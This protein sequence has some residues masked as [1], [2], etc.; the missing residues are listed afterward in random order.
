MNPDPA[1]TN[2]V[3]TGAS[4]GDTNPSI[5]PATISIGITPS[6][7]RTASAAGFRQRLAPR[8]Q[9]RR[10]Q[11]PG[12]QQAGAA[13]D[14]DRR[15]FEHAVRRDEAPERQAHARLMAG[16]RRGRRSAGR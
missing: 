10:E 2:L 16:D 11:P 13:G 14:E 3:E 12:D 8:Q 9:A 7:S 15:Q 5:S 1:M 4:D 6:S